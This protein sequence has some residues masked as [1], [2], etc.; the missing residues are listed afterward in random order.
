MTNFATAM[1]RNP[2]EVVYLFGK[3]VYFNRKVSNISVKAL[4]TDLG[5]E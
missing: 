3:G 2:V 5:K 4:S 1:Y